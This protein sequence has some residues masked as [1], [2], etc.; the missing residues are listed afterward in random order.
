MRHPDPNLAWPIPSAAVRLIAEREGCRL[1]A[2]LCPA[3]VWTI[4][5]GRTEGVKPGM[6]CTQAEADEW[7]RDD[8][9]ERTALVR[10]MLTTH[11]EPNALG[12]LV[13]LAYNIGN[14][15]LQKSSVLRAHNAGD[16]Q[17]A[18]RAFQLWN[19]A[20]VNGQLTVLPGLTARRAAEAALYLTPEPEAPVERMPQAVAA[21]SSIAA[22]PIA[23][24]GAVTAGAGVV[25]VLS[26]A[27][28]QLGPVGDALGQA[29]TVIV[30]TLG[31]PPGWVLPVVLVVIGGVVVW[32]RVKQR[33]GGWC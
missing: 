9:I 20:R 30:G 22:S 23:Q 26:E 8:L 29:K 4:G 13:S 10:V 14:A 32:Q 24:G 25:S 17:G 15:A 3:G 1:R 27:Q 6:T 28:A 33:R 31:L 21:E 11:A 5:W 19:K 12:A 16:F 7:L 2:Y 18:A